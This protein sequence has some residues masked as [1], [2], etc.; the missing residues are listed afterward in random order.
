MITAST[1]ETAE[2]QLADRKRERSRWRRIRRHQRSCYRGRLQ[3]RQ[4]DVFRA[5]N[6]LN[7]R[8]NRLEINCRRLGVIEVTPRGF[9]PQSG[10]LAAKPAAPPPCPGGSTCPNRQPAANRL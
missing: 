7:R 6:M 1:S 5:G 9:L 4:Y 2:C 3:R 8:R 10:I